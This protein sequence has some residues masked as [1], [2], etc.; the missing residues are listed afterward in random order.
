MTPAIM[1][2]VKLPDPKQFLKQK[3]SVLAG[4]SEYLKDYKNYE[5]VMRAILEAG[6]T[7]HSHGEMVDWAACTAC[8][9]K[10]W[11]RKEFIKKLGFRSPAQFLAWSKTHRIINERV[12]LPKYNS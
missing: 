2:E 6:S 3:P 4:L 7:K 12:P 8:Q 1:D 9:Q 10:L 11:D 5:K